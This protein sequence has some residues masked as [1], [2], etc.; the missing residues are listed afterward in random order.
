DRSRTRRPS[1]A[2]WPRWSGSL[3]R[4]RRR[5]PSSG[6]LGLRYAASPQ[7][8]DDPGSVVRH[9]VAA[10]GFEVVHAA[11]EV[12]LDPR[13]AEPQQKDQNRNGDRANDHDRLDAD[14]PAFVGVHALQQSA[15]GGSWLHHI[16]L[17]EVA[18]P[19]SESLT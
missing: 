2:A 14:G 12:I 18:A 1:A 10:L 17:S 3:R 13:P 6:A 19:R 9:D 8:P 4:L 7:P 11:V 15:E 5:G 16:L